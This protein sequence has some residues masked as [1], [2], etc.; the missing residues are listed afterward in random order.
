MHRGHFLSSGVAV[1]LS[2]ILASALTAAEVVERFTL[3]DG[4]VLLGVHDPAAN[5]IRTTV[6]QLTAQIALG[7][8]T[9]ASRERLPAHALAVGEP[10]T[11]RTPPTGD[12]PAGQRVVR[13]RKLQQRAPIP[14]VDTSAYNP[15]DQQD[16]VF[17][18]GR[19]DRDKHA[20][21][22]AEQS[23]DT[24]A[25]KPSVSKGEVENAFRKVRQGASD[26]AAQQRHIDSSRRIYRDDGPNRGQRDQEQ[27]DN[28]NARKDALRKALSSYEA[29]RRAYH[30]QTGTV[31]FAPASFLS[32]D[33]LANAKSP[34]LM[35]DR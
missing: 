25:N 5:T 29:A 8:L 34:P 12:L 4:R 1:L 23:N 17:P 7:Q 3:S 27:F 35:Q 28:L 10:V 31:V 9:I 2:I 22:S 20:V 16:L 11:Q 33:D 30:Q 15:D 6:G 19:Q 26:V 21:I 18:E 14:G 24:P 32:T 13:G